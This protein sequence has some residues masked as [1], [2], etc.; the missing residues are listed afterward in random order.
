MGEDC[1]DRAGRQF[2]LG[3]NDLQPPGF[4][5]VHDRPGRSVDEPGALHGG[6][7]HAVDRIRAHA[8][9]N[10]HLRGPVAVEQRPFRADAV[11]AVNETIVTRQ[12]GKRVRR[13]GLFEIDGRRAND[14]PERSKLADD[15]VES[16]IEPIRTATSI[17]SSSRL[18]CRSSSFTSMTIL[19]C[20]TANFARSG[21]K[22]YRPK[23]VG[24]AT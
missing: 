9:R 24:P 17:P 19:G 18:S 21:S 4:D 2:V 20:I 6:G 22:K 23:S 14:L 12:V 8:D 16:T 15:E 3:Q 10:L 5:E 7:Y 13:A 1:V 11:L